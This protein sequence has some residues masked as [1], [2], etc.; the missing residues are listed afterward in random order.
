MIVLREKG[1]EHTVYKTRCEDFI[2]AGAPLALQKA[3][4]IASDG[5][6]FLLVLHG[7][8]H[9]VNSLVGLGGRTYCGKKHGVAHAHFHCA[10]C[11]F[12]QFPRLDGNLTAV[13]KV[14]GLFHWFQHK[15]LSFFFAALFAAMPLRL[16]PRSRSCISWLFCHKVSNI[17]RFSQ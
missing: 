9:K 10:I 4:G 3:A 7:E 16:L 5:G 8:G 17:N 15:S 2:V 14:D 11:L 1:T 12:G 6:I 13:A